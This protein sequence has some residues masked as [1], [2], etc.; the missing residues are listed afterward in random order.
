M[1]LTVPT[2]A[3]GNL[4]RRWLVPSLPDVFFGALLIATFCHPQGLG[5]LLSDGDTGWHIRAGELILQTGRVPVTDPFS[6]S[7]PQQPW[8]AWEW[9]ADLV[10]TQTWRWRGLAG[11]AALAGVLLA[12]GATA[13]LAR[14]LRRRRGLWVRLAPA[15]AAVSAS[16]IRPPA[17]PPPLSLPL[18]SLAPLVLTPLP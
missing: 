2:A 16:S 11:V 12:L 13:T 8:F 15:M 18:F 4:L 10:F 1:S 14:I 5:S 17:P 7:R 3:T 6:F 9:L